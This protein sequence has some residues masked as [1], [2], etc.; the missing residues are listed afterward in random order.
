MY[1]GCSE[2]LQT[3]VDGASLLKEL[4]NPAH[5][6]MATKFLRTRLTGKAR[7]GLPQDAKTIDT[8]GIDVK[9]RCAEVI[10]T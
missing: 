2:D 4:T 10:S 8:I 9:T 7:Q 3:F 1:Y 5:L 6:E